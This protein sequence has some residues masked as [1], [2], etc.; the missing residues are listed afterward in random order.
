MMLIRLSR[1]YPSFLKNSKFKKVSPLLIIFLSILVSLFFVE[2]VFRIL[3]KEVTKI[4]FS[5]KDK[6]VLYM[7]GRRYAYLPNSSRSWTSLGPNTVW[8]FNNI[9]FRDRSVQII[10]PENVF[11]II[12]LGDSMIMG[13]GVEE[14][15]TIPRQMEKIFQEND[16]KAKTFIEVINLGMFGYGAMEYRSVMQEWGVK[17]KPDLVIVGTFSNDARDD[18][19]FNK[20]RKYTY[21]K[22]VADMVPYQV[23]QI[24]KKSYLYL[25]LLTK[26]YNFIK[27]Y[28]FQGSE[29][30]NAVI[31][32]EGYEL[33]GQAINDIKRMSDGVGAEFL[34]V[35][36]PDFDETINN[37]ERVRDD[38]LRQISGNGIN[39][40]D[41]E[42]VIRNI[43]DRINYYLNK[44]DTHFSPYGN[45]EIA[46]IL[47][48]YLYKRNLVPL[49]K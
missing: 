19:Y 24:L 48:D 47:V 21:L 32:T 46:K 12:V 23:N 6:I 41:L 22:S 40:F 4:D 15:E 37:V 2:V 38:K 17:L 25:F 29:K 7:P 45:R 5:I 36:I 31:P 1:T 28:Q 20:D 35:G 13:A 8:K 44:K 3:P 11:R 27:T 9:G 16:P 18:F 49:S 34:L 10:K 30:D 39:F 33:T 43:K 14:Y 26:Y 42:V